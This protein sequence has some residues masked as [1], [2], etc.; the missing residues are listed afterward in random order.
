MID[1]SSVLH[2]KPFS[3]PV[4]ATIRIPGSKSYTNRALVIAALTKGQVIL[5]RP[6]YSEDTEAM[7][8]CLHQL[9]LRIDTSADQ[10]VVYND[11]SVVSNK[12]YELFANASGTT[13][14][15]LL[16]LL[17]LTPGTQVLR[18]TKRLNERPIKDLVDALCSIGAK[19]DYLET[20]GQPPLKILSST[21]RGDS[22]V[23]VNATMSSQFVSALL[24]IAPILNSLTINVCGDLMSKPYVDMTIHMMKEWGIHVECAYDHTYYIPPG[25]HYQKQRYTIQGD[26]S[27]AGYF[28]AA[29]AL[30]HSTLTLENLH[31]QSVQADRQLLTILAAMG[32]RFTYQDDAVT[33][34]GKG[35]QPITINMQECPDQVQTMAVLAAFAEGKSTISGV[36]SLRLK[37]TERIL[38]LKTELA[39]MGI[40]TEDDHDTLTIYGGCPKAAEIDT[41]GDHRM[42]MAFAVAGTK[43]PGMRIK[44]P[45]V[46]NK[47]FPTFWEELKKL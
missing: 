34:I 5:D 12:C 14:R 23:F 11:I 10:I 38:A 21:L 31:P 24:M 7:L 36:R 28:F 32:S 26:Y 41:Y 2:I 39:K 18:G 8:D 45:E 33:I 4:K 43:L 47:T 30:T 46:V 25:Q 9:G 17:A 40:K 19:I 27:S 13:I 1:H 37:E 22:E 6:L 29:A 20:T 42:A 35:I 3:E 44:H 16:A 15:F